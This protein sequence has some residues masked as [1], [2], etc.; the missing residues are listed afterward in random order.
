[1]HELRREGPLAECVCTV[2]PLTPGVSYDRRPSVAERGRRNGERT[3]R[4]TRL[5]KVWIVLAALC[6]LSCQ[7]QP[8]SSSAVEGQVILALTIPGGATIASVTWTV[9]SSS[10]QL[11]ASGMTNTSRSGASASFAVGLPTGTGDVVA[12]TATTSNGE[13]CSGSSAPFNVV[14]NQTS[15]V[16]VSL[17]CGAVTSDGGLGSVLVTGTVVPGDSCP[18]LASWT[19]SPQTA[20]ANGGQIDIAA[21]VT[22]AD[23]EDTLS[24]LWSAVAGSFASSTAAAT[25]Y[26]CGAAGSQ[27]LH[28]I[29]SDNHTPIP[30]SLDVAFPPVSCN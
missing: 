14:A 12:M 3:R 27:L 11:L 7:G 13:T 16:S 30:C 19:I 23:G 1:M 6:G 4:E 2:I 18:A 22:D 15:P 21:T 8:G 20:V 9:E 24:Y 5:G 29:V 28:L 10:N 17:N 25:T 26:T